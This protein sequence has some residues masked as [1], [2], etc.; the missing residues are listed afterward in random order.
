MLAKMSAG[1]AVGAAAWVAP[2]ILTATP[3][4]GATLS[5]PP[6]TSGIVTS[7]LT[8]PAV[9]AAAPAGSTPDGTSSAPSTLASLAMTGLDLQRD[10]AIGATMVVGGW[11]MHRWSSR[12]PPDAAE[13]TPP[14]E[15]PKSPG[16][17]S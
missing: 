7:P 12:V 10:A 9:T 1:A 8:S 6:N 3:A 14:G 2:Q 4:R 13:A 5:G 17:P 15:R 16:D 11:A